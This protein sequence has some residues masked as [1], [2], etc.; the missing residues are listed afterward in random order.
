MKESLIIAFTAIA[1]IGINNII[2]SCKENETTPPRIGVL[3]FIQTVI[4][5]IGL[6]VVC[7]SNIAAI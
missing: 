5:G 1:C 7:G 4:A 6:I 2:E 3:G